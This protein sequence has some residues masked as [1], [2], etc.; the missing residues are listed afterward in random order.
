MNNLQS[1][2]SSNPSLAE[3]GKAYIRY[4]SSL[5]L[6]LDWE[7]FEKIVAIIEVAWQKERT[8][9][10]IGNGGSAVTASHFAND[11]GWYTRHIGSQRPR[12]ISLT[13]NI[14]LI[15]AIGNDAGYENIFVEQLKNL[16]QPDD[17]LI[18]ISASGN[19]SNILCAVDYANT[20]DGKTIGLTGFVGGRLKQICDV[21]LL[22][23]TDFGEYGPVEDAH[24][25]VNHLLIT[26]LTE[27]LS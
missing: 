27:K 10:F 7:A 25:I 26:Y 24:L 13:D 18:A 8:V 6:D 11:F 4:L 9:F 20:H 2:Y 14:A 16:F 1:I 3:Y 23:S 22:I 12:A 5:L 19:S 15:T 21:C 17:V